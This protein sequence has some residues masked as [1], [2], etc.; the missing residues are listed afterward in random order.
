MRV[1]VCKDYNEMSEKAFEVMKDVITKNPKAVLGLA[2]GSSPEGLYKCMVRDHEENGTSYQDI[3]T[4]N[5]DEYV[6]LPKN[7]PESYYTFM[8][9]NLFDHIDIKEENTHLPSGST[10]E[11]ADTYEKQWDAVTCDLQL[12]GIG[13]NGHIG[14]NEPGTPFAQTTHI[15]DL[16]PSTIEANSRFFDHDINKVPKQAISMGIGS[17]LK[18]KK[19]LLVASGAEKADAVKAM[20]EG[21]ATESCPASALQ[22]HDDVVVV[23]DQAAAAGLDR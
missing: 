10:Q 8:H 9:K 22:K 23:L 17:I 11:E 5:L 20:I 12:L 3:T 1:I 2:T 15:V 18:A 7:H 21:P 16:T 14:F 4:Y 13:R 19:I 6:G